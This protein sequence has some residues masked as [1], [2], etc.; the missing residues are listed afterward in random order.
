MEFSKDFLRHSLMYEFF[1]GQT[2][3][4]A[5]RN[6]C[7]VFGAK[8]PSERTCERWFKKFGDGKFSIEDEPRTG[9]PI[10]TENEKLFYL[11]A[12][13]PQ[14]STREIARKLGCSHTT[15]EKHLTELDFVQKLGRW[16][17][18]HLTEFQKINRVSIC[19]SLLTR[20]RKKDWV[21]KVITGDEK[22]ILYVNHTRKRQWLPRVV[23]PDPEATTQ[24]H[25][26]K[27]M[28][29]VF[30]DSKGI[31]WWELLPANA[32]IKA[33]VYCDQLEKLSQSIRK[34]RPFLEKVTFLHDNARPHV[35][36]QTKTKLEE[37]G[38]EVLPHPAYSPDLAPTDYHLFRELAFRF[39][40][41]SFDDFDHVFS[42]ISDFFD[43][44]PPAFFIKGMED[45]PVRWNNVVENDGE[46]II[47]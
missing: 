9:R 34:K 36:K 46:Y 4:G 10:E 18:H 41:K 38:W 12:S 17:P 20:K 14:M 5:Y 45:L 42:S 2:A 25:G 1:L 31:I 23:D 37:L 8:A 32:T 11:I 15:I 7:K 24:I 39:K 21:G 3:A 35:A 47:D 44:L 28:I 40:E 26:K 6:L 13:E 43:S 22:W 16:V 29:S 19:S 27:V 33:S 30:W